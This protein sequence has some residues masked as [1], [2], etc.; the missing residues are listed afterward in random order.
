[1][2]ADFRLF[3]QKRSPEQFRCSID[4]APLLEASDSLVSATVTA[5]RDDTGADV[6]ATV[7]SGAG[8]AANLAV[9]TIR[10][11]TSGLTYTATVNAHTTQGDIFERTFGWQVQD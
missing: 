3:R 5:R 4:F 11:G 7:I 6:T 10:A 2:I 1:V 8:I 9:W